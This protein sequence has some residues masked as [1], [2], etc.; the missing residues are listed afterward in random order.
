MFTHT[1]LTDRPSD[2]RT[3]RLNTKRT[4][5]Q[6]NQL[7]NQ[8]TYE[9]YKEHPSWEPDVCCATQGPIFYGI[10]KSDAVF[11]KNAGG[12]TADP[13]ERSPPPSLLQDPQNC[14]AS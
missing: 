6:T 12:L 14:T 13:R 7:T 2:Q 5:Q 9:L 11:G 3:D 4:N 8:L 10:P 1:R